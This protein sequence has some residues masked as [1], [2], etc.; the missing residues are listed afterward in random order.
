VGD[1]IAHELVR[2]SQHGGIAPTIVT[3]DVLFGLVRSQR[4]VF[5]PKVTAPGESSSLGRLNKIR[6][7][8]VLPPR[9]NPL[10]L[11]V[12]VHT[13]N[14]F[15]IIYTGLKSKSLSSRPNRPF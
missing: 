10:Y 4:D 13:R 8:K 3:G 11:I 14:T 15:Q 7:S 9:P 2:Q 1:Y 5:R 12:V 6:A